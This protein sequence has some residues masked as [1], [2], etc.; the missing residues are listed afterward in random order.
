MIPHIFT[1]QIDSE[2]MYRFSKRKVQGT[3]SEFDS[4]SNYRYRNRLP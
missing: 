2:Y 1:L 3:C 4:K